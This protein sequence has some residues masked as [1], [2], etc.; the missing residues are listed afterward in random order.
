M[1]KNF[2]YRFAC[3][4]GIG[5]GFIIPGVSGSAIAMIF[6]LYQEMVDSV[7]QIFKKFK[8]SFLFLLP[9]ALGVGASVVSLYFPLMWLLK[10]N[11]FVIIMLFAGLLLG[12]LKPMLKSVN[13]KSL[14]KWNYI[15]FA[16][17]FLMVV[18]ISVLS[19]FIKDK[20][21]D[22]TNPNAFNYVMMFVCGILF[23][24][25]TVVPG[26]S[27]TA[28]LLAVGYY[29]P[30]F[31]GL[32]SSTIHGL[33]EFNLLWKN[34]FLLGLFA[35]GVVVG[36]FV[37]AKII[38]VCFDK[39]KNVTFL[40]ISGFAIGSIPAMFISQDW[41]KT[42]FNDVYIKLPISITTI[43]VGIIL[44]VLGF[45]LSYFLVNFKERKEAS[46]GEK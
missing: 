16:I 4:F 14:K 21:V 35:L 38:N 12:S 17:T 36:A 33:L 11:C 22:L 18:G 24:F 3:G 13:W 23:A 44:L 10:K 7:S 2:L 28:L 9:I 43:V 42:Q 37:F 26:I 27:G 40:A 32:I 30:I 29:Y 6:N 34:Y 20:G 46:L 5:F 41:G 19:F 31:E 25:S 1:K 8:T 45:A 39:F 15:V